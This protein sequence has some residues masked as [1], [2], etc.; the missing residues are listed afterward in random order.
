MF[1]LSVLEVVSKCPMNY[2]KTPGVNQII[3]VCFITFNVIECGI[4]VD[5]IFHFKI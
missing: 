3:T 4:L 1:I 5:R 2:Y